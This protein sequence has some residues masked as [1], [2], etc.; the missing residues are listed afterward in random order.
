MD[1][2]NNSNGM[3]MWEEMAEMKNFMNDIKIQNTKL[4]TQNTQLITEVSQLKTEVSQLK[5]EVTQL[6]GRVEVLEEFKSKYDV[7]SHTLSAR[8]V[9]NKA[10]IVAM[11]LVFPGCRKDTYKIKSLNNLVAFINNNPNGIKF[12]ETAIQA[13]DNLPLEEQKGMSDRLQKLWNEHPKLFD[14]IKLLK[15]PWKAAHE[16]IY[17]LIESTKYYDE[18]SVDMADAVKTCWLFYEEVQKKKMY[19]NNE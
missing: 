7:L 4:I 6:N 13:R 10:D 3:N 14:S 8:E 12:S 15:S 2:H 19:Q 17:E 16:I 5:T 9:G 1:F 11:D 18:V